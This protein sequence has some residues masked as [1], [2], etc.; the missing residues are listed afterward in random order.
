MF[1]YLSEKT[2]RLLTEL[3]TNIQ[4]QLKIL[5]FDKVKEE[6]GLWS[7]SLSLLRN[8]SSQFSDPENAPIIIL[9]D[10][11]EELRNNEKLHAY[12][13]V[14]QALTQILQPGGL[15]VLTNLFEN[16]PDLY[17]KVVAERML[18]INHFN[19][20]YSDMQHKKIIGNGLIILHE[21]LT[22]QKNVPFL[23]YNRYLKVYN[24]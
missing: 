2:A 11:T 18:I 16:C 24:L 7:L 13:S 14:M 20:N 9:E 15:P 5:I 8:C 23:L 3:P 4:K 10:I 12:G 1:L 21:L 6:T 22:Q 17:A 19:E